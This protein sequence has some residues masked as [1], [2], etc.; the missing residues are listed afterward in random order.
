MVRLVLHFHS[1]LRVLADAHAGGTARQYG[2]V[3]GQSRGNPMGLDDLCVL[4]LTCTG[5][6]DA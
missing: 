1:G 6:V 4:R 5:L 2:F 3:S